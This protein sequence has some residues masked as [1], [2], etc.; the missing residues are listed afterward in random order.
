MDTDTI[1]V[2][3]PLPPAWEDALIVLGVVVLVAL[4]AFFCALIFGAEGRHRRKH[5]RHHHQ[6]EGYRE[7]F[8]KS[9]SGIKQF[10]RQRHGERHREHRPTNP[11]LA[12]TGG[13][14]PIHEP[15]KQ[16]PPPLP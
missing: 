4:I 7:Q 14:P 2:A 15:D 8:K 3:S 13:L 1:P 12:E 11:T 6:R 16:P 9:A 10:I 5:H